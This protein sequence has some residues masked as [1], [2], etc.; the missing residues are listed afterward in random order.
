MKQS[1]K[2]FVFNKTEDYE[3]GCLYNLQLLDPGIQ[4]SDIT[5]NQGVFFSRLFDSREQQLCWHRLQMEGDTISEASVRMYIYVSE[6]PVMLWEGSERS[7]QEL[8]EDASI[9]PLDKHYGMA[10]YITR[11]LDDPKDVLLHDVTGRYLWIE[12]RMTAQGTRTPVIRTMKLSFPKNTWL[13]YLPD[14][15]QEHPSSASFVERY[16]GIY[17][18]LYEDMKDE[19]NHV[20][21]YFDPE[22]V[23]GPF[24]E[25]L[26]SWLAI[27]DSYIWNEEQLKYL[28]SNAADLYRRR[29]TVS[30]ME[31][32]LELYTGT[33]IY[34]VE[35]HQLEKYVKHSNV[36]LMTELYG[37]SPHV[38]TIIVYMESDNSNRSY[39]ILTRIVE[40]AKPAHIECNIIVLEPYIFLGKHSYMGINTILG[41]YGALVLDGQASIPFIA[42]LDQEQ[43]K[44]SQEYSGFLI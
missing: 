30:Y 40:R 6:T 24:V 35:Y 37:N 36:K 32:M 34:I 9:D 25:W 18:S 16:L 33:M 12:I 11:V 21:Q 42:L 38:V 8:I 7:I 3:R 17:Q 41:S 4:I 2:Y 29:G 20:V 44:S 31:D 39:Q 19:I 1:T 22:V 15:Y 10:K 43:E 5:R 14:I 27:E 28:I 23:S 26:A 13:T